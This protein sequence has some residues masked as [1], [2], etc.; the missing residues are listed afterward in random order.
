METEKT[1][2]RWRRRRRRRF[3]GNRQ[4]HWLLLTFTLAIQCS[5]ARSEIVVFVVSFHFLRLTCERQQ[6]NEMMCIIVFTTE[7]R[8]KSF[9]LSRFRCVLFFVS[10][11]RSSVSHLDL[12]FVLFCG[13][14]D[15]R[16]THAHIHRHMIVPEY[17]SLSGW[18]LMI[19]RDTCRSM[20]VFTTFNLNL[21]MDTITT[22][23]KHTTTTP[24]K[25]R[26]WTCDFLLLWFEHL[27][28]DVEWRV[29]CVVDGL[30][31]IAI[32]F[33]VSLF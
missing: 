18:T 22:G 21:N 9:V 24:T 33:L 15:R 32:S 27:R 11:S 19:G 10:T 5:S 4:K 12:N 31:T 2:R 29:V 17:V 16:I 30:T 3:F 28:C 20:F 1:E 13:N 14:F 8:T 26:C 7:T 6:C 25:P 23:R